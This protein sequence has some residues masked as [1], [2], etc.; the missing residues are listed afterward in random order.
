MIA[1]LMA[2]GAITRAAVSAP[3]G[4]ILAVGMPTADAPFV[5]QCAA[6]HAA[7]LALADA[8][9]ARHVEAAVAVAFSLTT[10]GVAAHLLFRRGGERR[11]RCQAQTHGREPSDWRCLRASYCRRGVS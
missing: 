10:D 11:G 7:L 3:A 8:G 4:S 1:I 9:T 5:A 2:T 6:R